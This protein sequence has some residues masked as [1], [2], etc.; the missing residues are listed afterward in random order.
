M[1]ISVIIPTFNSAAFISDAIESVFSQ[2]YKDF[3]V[4][5]VDDGSTDNT[6]SVVEYYVDKYGDRIRYF[7]KENRGAGSARNYGVEHTGGGLIAFLDSDDLWYPE[8]MERALITLNRHPDCNFVCHSYRVRWDSGQ[9]DEFRVNE[10]YNTLMPE[11]MFREFFFENRIGTSTVVMKKDLFYKAGGFDESI[12]TGQD[13]DLW[14]RCARVA[15]IYFLDEILSE[16]RRRKGSITSFVEKKLPCE[17]K[18]MEKYLGLFPEGEREQIRRQKLRNIYVS[19][20]MRVLESDNRI[21]SRRYL[22]EGLKQQPFNLRTI[23]LFFCVLMFRKPLSV[24]AR[25]D[26][27]YRSL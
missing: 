19:V 22:L 25:L 3:E 10:H 26:R 12:W 7:Y 24:V 2:T 9:K 27:L 23:I 14:V 5:V 11:Q 21:L 13:Y 1:T 16:Y 6:R 20:A 17:L 4:I 15:K 8:K 18:I